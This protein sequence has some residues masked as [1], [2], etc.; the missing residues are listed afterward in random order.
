MKTEEKPDR[1]LII[2]LK[3]GDELCFE[4]LLRKYCPRFR[5]Y[6]YRLIHD[7]NQ[8]EDIL[9]NVFMKLWMNRLSLD[10]NTSI[11]AYL[12]VLTRNEILN[13]FR[14]IRSHPLANDSD[15][16]VPAMAEETVDNEFHYNDLYALLLKIIDTK[17]PERRREIF[18][19]NRFE[20]LAPAEIARN[21]GLS[22]RTVEKHIELA[23][24]TIRNTLGPILSLI[25]FS[26]HQLF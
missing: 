24:R 17:L 20:H 12:F 8:A 6:T 18:K 13:Y 7:H 25:L 26:S 4:L 3:Y 19:M 9:Q 21:L 10:E 1:I 2:G 11:V 14:Y 5:A 23:L 22:T 16:T 15:T